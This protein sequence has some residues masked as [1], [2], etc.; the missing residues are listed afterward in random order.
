MWNGVTWL[1]VGASGGL[2]HARFHKVWR[3]SCLPG[4]ILT[5]Q[6]GPCSTE[7]NRLH[8]HAQ[9]HSFIIHYQCS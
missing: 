5:S 2:L 1:N 3:I 7:L 4:E 6:E 9:E 8:M